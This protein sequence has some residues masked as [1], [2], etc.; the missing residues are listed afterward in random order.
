MISVIIPV[1]NAERFIKRCILSV[2]NQSYTE[3]EAILVDDGSTD[4]TAEII[5]ET[6]KNDSR[7]IYIYQENKGVSSARNK[8]LESVSGEYVT[9]L[10]SD[11]E[12]TP[13]CLKNIVQWF[14][15]Y[16][17]DII[18]FPFVALKSTQ[19][20]RISDE[21]ANVQP[22]IY[23]RDEAIRKM[24]HKDEFK[25]VVCGG[26]CKKNLIENIRFDERI[27]LGE[28]CCFE[29]TAIAHAQHI[30][31]SPVCMYI[32]RLEV[33]SITRRQIT[34][35]DIQ[36]VLYAMKYVQSLLINNSSIQTELN[37]YLFGEYMG[38][39]NRMVVEKTS[40]QGWNEQIELLNELEMLMETSSL[41]TKKRYAY[42]LWKYCPKLYGFML[43][44][45]YEVRYH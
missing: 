19:E 21:R 6:I 33:G 31:Y 4:R 1:Y 35:S 14:E 20:V 8:A 24:L 32:Q 29:F 37:N 26:A 25:I 3:W 2:K 15:Q 13:N 44:M 38:Y 9:F 45:Y 39:L 5:K 18:Q 41:K 28:D 27:Y 40:G 30:L 22:V 16:D 43:R 34:P 36:N 12:L 10:D 11:D 23:T 7:C 42:L 17:V